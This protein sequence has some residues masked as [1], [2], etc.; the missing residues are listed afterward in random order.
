MNPNTGYE[1]ISTAG[2]KT[3]TQRVVDIGKQKTCALCG[4]SRTQRDM[5]EMGGGSGF[6]R[7]QDGMQNDKCSAERLGRREIS[8]THTPVEKKERP[9]VEITEAGKFA[10]RAANSMSRSWQRSKPTK[11]GGSGT[12]WRDRA[13]SM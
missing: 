2:S 13:S 8:E 5:E 4:Q 12:S 11:S 3:V 6:F 7:C 1:W 10:E 9:I